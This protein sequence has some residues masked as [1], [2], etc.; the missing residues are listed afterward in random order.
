MMYPRTEYEMTE[1][2][3]AVAWA[4]LGTKIGMHPTDKMIERKPKNEAIL[5]PN[6]L[7][8]R[9][10][11]N[12]L[13]SPRPARGWPLGIGCGTIWQARRAERDEV[14]IA[15]VRSGHRAR[16]CS[17]DRRNNRLIKNG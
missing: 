4:S 3:L 7:R 2:D 11:G 17:A 8:T 13:F 14:V 6:A 1:E 16:P 10:L 15:A 5:T 12:P 9:P